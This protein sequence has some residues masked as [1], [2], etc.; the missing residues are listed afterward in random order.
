MNPAAL[1]PTP[2][3][4]PVPWGWLYV[5]LMLTFLLHVMVMNA[6]L[7]G[8]IISLIS[9]I[10]GGEQNR[11]LS[12]E[13]SFKWPYTIAFAVNM[14]V[15]PLLFVQVIYGHFMYTS[16][17]MMA[18]WWLSIIALL[19]IAYY[20]AYI[21]DFKFETLGSFRV[22]MVELSVLLLLLIAFFFSNNMTLMMQPDRWTGFFSN[23]S[24]TMLNIGDPILIPR[25]LHFVVGSVAVAGL[26]MA[27][28]GRFNMR[29][30]QVDKETMINKG[31]SYFTGATL[32]QVCIG[33]WFLL[34]LPDGI[35]KLFMGA[36][37]YGTSMLSIGIVLAIAVLYFGYKKHVLRTCTLVLLL[38][39]D[40]IF[41]RDLVRIAYLKPYF[42]M[43]D[44]VVK[45]EYSPMIFFFV[46]FAGGLAMI[47]YM[48]KLALECRK[49]VSK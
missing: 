42:Q 17:V 27:L 34:S 47:A 21:Y 18:V 15:A 2:D 8:G 12:R 6:M 22:L 28:I 7:G 35:M 31:M 44:L 14:G 9:L 5:L 46:V 45:T 29:K 38:L 10:R 16:S 49:E 40:M 39:I 37:A 20:S 13:F 25:Y 19:I 26:Y 23:S 33:I 1:V 11:L 4:I 43:S 3:A 32:I 24:G 36:S 48:L 41:M 30:S